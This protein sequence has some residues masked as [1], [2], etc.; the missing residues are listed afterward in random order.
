MGESGSGKS[1]IIH[2]LLRLYDPSAGAVLLDGRD[3]RSLPLPW[4]RSQVGLVAQQPTLFA[5]SIYDNIA[6]DSGAGAEAVVA[7]ALAANAHGFITRLPNGWVELQPAGCGDPDC[8]GWGATTML[9]LRPP[10]FTH[11]LCRML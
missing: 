9:L 4:L 6:L 2:L 5:S 7:A 11:P 10:L 8:I 1:T 3:L